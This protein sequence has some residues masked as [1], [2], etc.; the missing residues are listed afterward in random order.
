MRAQY[1]LYYILLE[2]P[3]LEVC[4]AELI[5]LTTTYDNIKPWFVAKV[6]RLYQGKTGKRTQ[7]LTLLQLF[8]RLKI[9]M[10]TL[11]DLPNVAKESKSFTNMNQMLKKTLGA[12]AVRND[13]K[14]QEDTIAFPDSDVNQIALRS[15]AYPKYIRVFQ[16]FSNLSEFL[17]RYTVSSFD[18]YET[19]F[20]SLLGNKL[21]FVFLGVLS[22]KEKEQAKHY[23]QHIFNRIEENE[24][25]E[26]EIK[27]FLQHLYQ[28]H[29][30][31]D[32][33]VFDIRENLYSFMRSHD[34]FHYRQ[35]VRMKSKRE[36]L[37]S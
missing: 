14:V 22:P 34:F 21:N 36:F 19:C 16:Q 33:N 1:P 24:V 12:V 27:A 10:V 17:E 4:A 20:D 23:V 35:E 11:S 2:D 9:N 3:E 25:E 15:N 7:L 32:Q 8:R 37:I 26:E 6:Q 30:V 28:V 31:F 29:L 13:I 18:L 5:Y